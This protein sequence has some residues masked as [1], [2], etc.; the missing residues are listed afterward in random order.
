MPYAISFAQQYQTQLYLLHVLEYASAGTV[1]L[2]AD[3]DFACRR[4]RE[5]IS[6]EQEL[7]F[8]PQFFVEPGK[9]AETIRTFATKHGADLIVIGVQ[10][11]AHGVGALTHF[12]HTL[13]QEVVAYAT[14]PVLTM[15]G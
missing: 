1:N 13:P 7:T 5:M 12:G 10:A 8:P 2:D 11:A 4:L 6:P 14:C 15:R 9:A 3:M